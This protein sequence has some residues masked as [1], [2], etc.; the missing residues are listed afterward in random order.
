MFSRL[1]CGQHVGFLHKPATHVQ[2]GCN[3]QSIK[4][5]LQAVLRALLQLHADVNESN[6]HMQYGSPCLSPACATA[7]MHSVC[8]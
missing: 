2:T 7:C 1:L 8:V 4:H 6:V 3:A 5:R